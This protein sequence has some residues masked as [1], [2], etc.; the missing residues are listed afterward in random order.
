MLFRYLRD[1]RDNTKDEDFKDLLMT[2]ERD[3]KVNRTDFGKRTSPK[4]FIEICEIY[5]IVK[6][7]AA[8]V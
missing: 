4:E 5:R 1:L 2:T 3:I 7:R 6:G 8:N